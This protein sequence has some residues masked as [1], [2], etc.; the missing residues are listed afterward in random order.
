MVPILRTEIYLFL[1]LVISGCQSEKSAV[2]IDKGLDTCEYCRMTISDSHYAAEIIEKRKIHKF[3]DI[4]CLLAYAQTH[5]LNSGNA[6]FWVIDF[7]TVNWITGEE[8]YFVISPQI[9]TPMSHG[10]AA[11]KNP[12]KADEIADKTNG[13]VVRFESLFDIDWKTRHEH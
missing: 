5:N 3:D 6:R 11:F 10:I 7:D 13:K 8:A 4:G 1:M 9:H 12:I 2:P